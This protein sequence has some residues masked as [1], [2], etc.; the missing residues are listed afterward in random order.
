MKPILVLTLLGMLCGC[1][2]HA[3][4]LSAAM[5]EQVQRPL[6]PFRLRVTSYSMH[7]TLTRNQFINITPCL[8]KWVRVGMVLCVTSDAGFIYIHRVN[9]IVG[10][11]IYLKGDFNSTEDKRAYVEEDMPITFDQILGCWIDDR[12]PRTFIRP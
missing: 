3:Y 6:A 2:S 11:K 8:K 10:D 12:D 1:Q 4:P 5:P 9:R 7:P